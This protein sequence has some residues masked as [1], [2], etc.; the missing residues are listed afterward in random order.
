LQPSPKFVL[1]IPNIA[2]CRQRIPFDHW[3][4]S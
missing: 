3:R 2:H 4:F 1:V